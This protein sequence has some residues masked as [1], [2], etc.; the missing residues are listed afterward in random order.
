MKK[1]NS[2]SCRYR[3]DALDQL[4]GLEPEGQ[5]TLRRFY[6]LEHLA[7]EIQG[8]SSQSVLQQGTQLLALQSREGNAINSQLLATDQPRSVL[9]VTG[10][11]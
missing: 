11:G 4:T 8:L 7:T 5:A 2:G 9:R 1:F 3:Y 10:T 6:R